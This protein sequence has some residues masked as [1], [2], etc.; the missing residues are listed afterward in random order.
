MQSFCP[1]LIKALECLYLSISLLELYIKKLFLFA[2][3]PPTGHMARW[4]EST[5]TLQWN[6]LETNSSWERSMQLRELRRKKHANRQ[7]TNKLRKG[8][9]PTENTWSGHTKNP[10][11]KWGGN[12]KQYRLQQILFPDDR[13]CNEPSWNLLVVHIRKNCFWAERKVSLQIWQKG[14]VT[15]H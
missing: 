8:A 7:N 9:H 15:C 5:E 10:W 14:F 4:K 3:F 6:S 11:D 12:F 1:Q 13:K 2:I